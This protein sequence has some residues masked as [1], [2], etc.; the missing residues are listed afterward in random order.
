MPTYFSVRVPKYD[1]SQNTEAHSYKVASPF[2]AASGLFYNS[3]LFLPLDYNKPNLHSDKHRGNYRLMQSTYYIH[4]NTY[5]IARYSAEACFAQKE[6]SD[7]N[8]QQ[9]RPRH[10][11]SKPYHALTS[12]RKSVV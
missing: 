12:D 3:Y 8:Y 6:N 11:F 9:P 4:P 1:I 2:H 7:S 10:I 5:H